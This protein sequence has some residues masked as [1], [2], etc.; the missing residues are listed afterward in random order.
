[1]TASSP[2]DS[3]G[4]GQAPDGRH[5]LICYGVVTSLTSNRP[6]ELP[7]ESV[8]GPVDL[9]GSRLSVRG[10]DP[11]GDRTWPWHAGK[12]GFRP[13]GSHGFRRTISLRPTGC[14]VLN[15]TKPAR[16]SGGRFLRCSERTKGHRPLTSCPT[17]SAVPRRVFSTRSRRGT[18]VRP[19]PPTGPRRSCLLIAVGPLAKTHPLDSRTRDAEDV[20]GTSG[21]MS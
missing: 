1:M 16:S 18:K 3:S 10:E 11:S 17:G 9:S 2:R 21:G 4:E 15:A 8:L 13:S 5:V 12:T 6:R 14:R 7:T 19:L 20:I